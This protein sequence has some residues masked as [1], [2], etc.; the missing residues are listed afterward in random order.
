M[1]AI[2]AFLLATI[3]MVATADDPDVN[4][5]QHAIARFLVAN[6]AGDYAVI[7]KMRPPRQLAAMIKAAGVSEAEYLATS[8]SETEEAHKMMAIGHTRLLHD[9]LIARQTP[10]GRNYVKARTATYQRAL[11]GQFARLERPLIALE[12]SGNWYVTRAS[13]PMDLLFLRLAYPEFVEVGVQS[14]K[15]EIISEAELPDGLKG[16]E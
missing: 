1:K 11:L 6:E 7:E 4:V 10:D 15:A 5:A 12:D 13:K 16:A 8:R 9:S 2:I 3:P 14:D